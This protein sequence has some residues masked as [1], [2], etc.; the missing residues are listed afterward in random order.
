MKPMVTLV[1]CLPAALALIAC[2]CG[3]AYLCPPAARP[4]PITTL[5]AGGVEGGTWR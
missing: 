3:V 5:L 1:L 2:R 4:A